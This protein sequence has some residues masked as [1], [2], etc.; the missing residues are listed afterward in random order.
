MYSNS[1]SPSTYCLLEVYTGS[2]K[3]DIQ[4]SSLRV[5][6]NLNKALILQFLPKVF[7][8]ALF[9]LSK[10]ERQTDVKCQSEKVTI[11]MIYNY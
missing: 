1:L 2:G 9:G 5:D 11:M 7:L 4:K 8:E 10:P 6:P 3:L